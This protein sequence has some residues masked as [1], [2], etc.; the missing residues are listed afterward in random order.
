MNT[1]LPSAGWSGAMLG[2]AASIVLALLGFRAQRNPD[3]V[4][5]ARLRVT[6]WCMLGGAVLSMSALIGALVTD[7]FAMSYV[8]EVHSRSTP[9]FF[10]ITSAWASLGG[11]LVLWTLVLAGY[12]AVVARQVR[13]VE[14][15]LG[16]G[17]LGVMGVVGIFF[18]GLVTTVANPF[19]IMANPPAD[20]PGANPLL[21]D[22]IMVAFH[23]PMLYLGFVGFTVPFAFAMSALLLRRGGVDWLR[24]SR[25]AGLVAWSFLTGGLVLGAWWSYEVLGW[26]GYWAWDPVENAALIPWLVATA[27]LHSAVVQVKRGMLQSWNFVLVLATFALTI[28]GTFLTRS[29]VVVSV[30][31]FSQSAVGPALLAFF[32]LVLGGGFTLFALRGERMASLSRPERLASREGV[33]LVNNLLLT[34]FAFVVLTGT[35][36]PVLVEAVTG[37]QVSVGRPFFDRMAVPLS[38]GLLLAMGIGPFTPY[39][40]ATFGVMWMRLRIPLLIASSAA[41]AMVLA[42]VRDPGVVLVMFL[43]TAS[44]TA[45]VR[46]LV[47]TVPHPRPAAVW[48]L[49]RSQ[50]AYWGGQLA[51]LGVAVVAL[52]IVSSSAFAQRATVTL[53]RGASA[54]FAGYSVTFEKTERH[55]LSDRTSTDAH[56]V[57][58]EGGRVVRVAEPRLNVFAGRPQAVGQPSVWPGVA[59]DVY[60]ALGALEDNRVVLNLYRYPLMSWLWA[61]GALVAAGGFWAVSGRLRRKR[62]DEEAAPEVVS[63]A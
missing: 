23:P 33:F 49:L 40:H 47:V 55:E 20:G 1:V 14:D 63:R 39:R 9:L 34:V 12:T 27:F 57:L 13:S 37:A 58:R 32:V 26:G 17:A 7:N 5:H 2:L 48:R 4:R 15:R 11:S 62:T 41:A 30:H 36:Y 42:G 46:Q 24:R 60:V 25:R 19:T 8:A 29:S 3:R 43:V 44:V 59:Q 21:R 61:G 54:E 22:H 51:H 28:L 35:V 52:A 53:E 16:T 31:S 6:A 50:R 38:L 56:I 18:F 10:T 45:T